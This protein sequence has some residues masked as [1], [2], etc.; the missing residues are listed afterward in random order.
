MILG[1]TALHLGHTN[2]SVALDSQASCYLQRCPPILKISVDVCMPLGTVVLTRLCYPILP[3]PCKYL[4]HNLSPRPAYF[5]LVGA[6]I[7]HSD[8]F[9]WTRPAPLR[10][11]SF[12]KRVL[13]HDQAHY[14][15]PW[16][17][18][19]ES[20]LLL[21][22]LNSAGHVRREPITKYSCHGHHSSSRC[23]PW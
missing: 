8:L 11:Q 14:I 5:F 18:Q 4:L 17:L 9:R 23:L 10:H 15:Q 20:V 16:A 2:F 19:S 12:P 22:Y 13:F 7:C 1:V 21:G 3:R 6:G